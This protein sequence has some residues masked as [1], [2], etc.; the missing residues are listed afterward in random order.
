VIQVKVT[1]EV[2]VV[3]ML[4]LEKDVPMW[5]RLSLKR[6]FWVGGGLNALCGFCSDL[7]IVKSPQ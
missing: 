4:P 2:L 5:M 3:G 7:I 6:R 1:V